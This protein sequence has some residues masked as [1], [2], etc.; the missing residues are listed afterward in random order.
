MLCRVFFE[1]I[2]Y[3]FKILKSSSG[4]INNIF[5]YYFNHRIITLPKTQSLSV[6]F[7]PIESKYLWA[8]FYKI[9]ARMYVLSNSFNKELLT[10]I[11]DCVY[12]IFVF[13]RSYASEVKR[14]NVTYVNNQIKFTLKNTVVNLL[15]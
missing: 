14:N 3:L 8:N 12:Q 9:I 5:I 6:L 13:T 7:Q 11:E 10:M 4:P 15:T 1:I 2:H